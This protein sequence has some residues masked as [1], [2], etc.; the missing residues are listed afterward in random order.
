MTGHYGYITEE[1]AKRR[2]R[3]MNLID[4]F[5]FDQVA[6]KEDTAEEFSRLLLKPILGR[7]PG[8]LRVHVQKHLPGDY[9]SKHGARLDFLVEEYQEDGTETEL[10][11]DLF[12]YEPEKKEYEKTYLPKRVRFYRSMIDHLQLRSGLSY[13]KLPRVYIIF[14][15]D[16]D[17]FGLNRMVYT[18]KNRCIE[19]PDLPYEDGAENLFLYCEGEGEDVSRDIRSLLRYMVSSKKENAV[20][21]ELQRLHT[22]VEDVKNGTEVTKTAM[23]NEYVQKMHDDDLIRVTREEAIKEGREE[24]REEGEVLHL[25]R[26]VQRKLAKGKDSG[27]I[28]A[29]LEEDVERIQDIINAVLEVGENADAETV[30]KKMK[31]AVLFEE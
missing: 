18:V 21:N 2:V 7:E 22:I 19:A 9:P 11:T 26:M 17:P 13:E 8:R 15:T 31:Q 10:P 28:A 1:E 5:L 25:V 29:E 27:Q 14:I 16:F 20:S 4:S 30:Y 23:W 12:D 24:G 3:E 6:T